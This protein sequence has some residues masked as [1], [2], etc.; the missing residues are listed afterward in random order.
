[1]EGKV[2]KRANIILVSEYV[3]PSMREKDL[4]VVFTCFAVFRIEK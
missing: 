2:F 1:M 4:D 3:K